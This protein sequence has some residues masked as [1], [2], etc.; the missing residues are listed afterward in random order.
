MPP[1]LPSMEGE[2]E[3]KVSFAN[4]DDVIP[5]A[6]NYDAVDRYVFGSLRRSVRLTSSSRIRK[7]SSVANSSQGAA[8][9]IEEEDE[10]ELTEDDE[11]F[12]ESAA[13]AKHIEEN[14]VGN[15][16]I[17]EGPYGGREIVYCDYTASGRAVKFIEDYITEHVQPLY[18]N[19]HTTTGLM[20]RQTTKFRKEARDIIKKCVNAT[21]DDALIFTGSGTTG[22]VNKLVSALLL[23]GER[24]KKT[25]VFVGPYEHHSNL[26][27]WKE[28]GAKV[29]RI[30]DNSRGL[31]D[32]VAL[33]ES[34]EKHQK[35][36]RFLIGCFSAASNVTGI[37]SDTHQVAALLHKYGALSFWDYAT[38]GPY[39]AI[40]MNPDSHGT[41]DDFSKDAVYLSPHKFVGG[42]G[43]PGILIAKK[44]H[45]LNK[46]PHSV[47]G[48]TVLYVTNETHH[49]IHN[50]EEREEGGTPAIVESIRAGL[51]FRLKESVGID[52]IERREEELTKLAFAKWKKNPNILILG[53]SR[54]NRLSIFSFMI[55]HPKTGKMLH[56]NFVAVLLND[57]YGIQARGGCAC[58]G[59][60]AQDLLGINE[61]LAERFVYFLTDESKEKK[62]KTRR[63]RNGKRTDS[64]AS[65]FKKVKKTK[66]PMEIMKPGFVRLNLPFFFSDDVINYVLE[67]V[68]DIGTNGWKMLSQYT[69]DPITSEWQYVGTLQEE[70]RPSIS[71]AG[72][73]LLTTT[74][75][76]GRF[77]APPSPYVGPK[78]KDRDA[79]GT[80]YKTF[81]DQSTKLMK[82]AG[83]QCQ[84]PPEVMVDTVGPSIGDPDLIWF[85]RPYEAVYH[86][87][88]PEAD[89]MDAIP[90][91]TEG[92][93]PAGAANGTNPAD[94]RSKLTHAPF[95]PKRYTKRSLSRRF[96]FK[97]QPRHRKKEKKESTGICS[98]M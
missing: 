38:A 35:K 73:S 76:E 70:A 93:G 63:R 42:V 82:E 39:L 30:R 55:V 54:A 2:I 7:P 9:D 79:S 90:S 71:P 91:L 14:V 94:A 4:T 87:R 1:I 27:P 40:D 48:G 11:T 43:T 44:K 25:V 41:D 80:H 89:P 46:V 85:M 23:K 24:A 52:Y 65:E 59:P 92:D 19:T 53:S 96:S 33:E 62:E 84:F 37:I 78:T 20:A 6:E 10:D 75:K 22:A 67:A 21:D 8:S 29:I 81:L 83:H 31:I 45:F 97:K 26:L 57:L 51:T 64:T 49:Y 74:F 12:N 34:L 66:T 50:I 68:D 88:Y 28:T 58:A 60:Y 18:A 98:I 36:D 61:E 69:I 5:P 3:N 56:H 17:F 77:I 13:I 95:R 32:M 47:G 86:I 72:D 16:T 15:E